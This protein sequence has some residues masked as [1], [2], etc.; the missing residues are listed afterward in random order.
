MLRIN[1]CKKLFLVVFLSFSGIAVKAEDILSTKDDPDKVDY[2]YTANEDCGYETAKR[3]LCKNGEWSAWN[4]E[5]P[6]EKDEDD[7]LENQCWDG[8]ICLNK[9][10]EPVCFNDFLQ[11]TPN[12][13]NY[14][15]NV[16]KQ[17]VSWQC[18]P[19]KGFVCMRYKEIGSVSTVYPEKFYYSRSN[20]SY[21]YWFSTIPPYDPCEGLNW[22]QRLWQGDGRC[23]DN[24]RVKKNDF[25]PEFE[26]GNGWQY[27]V[28]FNCAY[29]KGLQVKD[30]CGVKYIDVDRHLTWSVYYHYDKEETSL[31]YDIAECNNNPIDIVEKSG[32]VEIK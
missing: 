10:P 16:G 2:W 4:E 1:C 8:K 14:G 12:H 19:G 17:C 30:F 31:D 21:D 29:V 23:N 3:F 18:T 5:C 9:P 24:A 11:M 7:C 32:P 13:S 6:K 25:C 15:N 28:C 26:K 20:T 22:W 27:R